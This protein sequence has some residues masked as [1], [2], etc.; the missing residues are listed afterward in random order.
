MSLTA[1]PRWVDR[2]LRPRV[3]SLL[4]LSGVAGCGDA[5]EPASV[6]PITTTELMA[7]ITFLAD[8]SLYGRG[9]GWEDELTA[10]EYVRGQFTDAG[11][12]PGAEDYLQTFWI[13]EQ[14]PRSGSVSAGAISQDPIR[15][16]RPWS[17]NVVG[18]FAGSGSLA[19][20][21]VVIGA[22][23]DHVGW[24]MEADNAL[25]IYNGADDNASGTAV[26]IEVAE[27][28]TA[29][30]SSRGEGDRRSLM[31]VAF[32]AEE[33]GLEG[34]RWF[35]DNPTV[36]LEHVAAMVNLDMVGRLRNEF[37]T[38]GAASSAAWWPELIAGANL[39]GL[40][41]NLDNKYLGGSD[42]YCFF[43]AGR[44]AVHFFTGLHAEYHTPADDPP[45]INQQGMLDV[46]ELTVR[47]VQ[48]LATRT[49]L[50]AGEQ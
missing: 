22:H 33:I 50:P 19:D 4:L 40:T 30:Y 6:E 12:A 27:Y 21:W 29:F 45:L 18:F 15:T 28:L 1:V 2:L 32:G 42:H 44:P 17:Q 11:L 5:A 7:H 8:D 31:F 36:P 9:A 41:L 38:V 26:L 49:S 37:L 47:V 16:S 13:G 39:D 24:G 48:D 46:A 35:C 3:A 25:V 23:Y 20:E 10:A 34:S 14:Q 43:L